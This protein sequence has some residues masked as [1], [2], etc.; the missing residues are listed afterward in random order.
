MQCAAGCSKIV[1]GKCGKCDNVFYCGSDC[2]ERAWNS[3][4]KF[5]CGAVISGKDELAD[6]VETDL[7][8]LLHGMKKPLTNDPLN[9]PPSPSTP[10]KWVHEVMAKRL[11]SRY[12]TA[13]RNKEMVDGFWVKTL[14]MR[15]VSDAVII[16][17]MQLFDKA[18][19]AFISAAPD[20]MGNMSPP[21]V[22][23]EAS[24]CVKTIEVLLRAAVDNTPPMDV[25]MEQQTKAHRGGG[26]AIGMK[27]MLMAT[28]Y[29]KEVFSEESQYVKD[30]AC[31]RSYGYEPDARWEGTNSEIMGKIKRGELPPMDDIN[32]VLRNANATGTFMPLSKN[33]SFIGTSHNGKGKEEEE[34]D[35]DT[36]ETLYV[37]PSEAMDYEYWKQEEEWNADWSL[38][39][40]E[41][42][43]V[44]PQ[45]RVKNWFGWDTPKPA[46]GVTGQIRGDY[47]GMDPGMESS[48]YRTRSQ[49]NLVELAQMEWEIMSDTSLGPPV[50]RRSCTSFIAR[51][52]SPTRF[53][54]L[55]GFT[56]GIGVAIGS[57]W[58]LYAFQLGFHKV[59]RKIMANVQAYLGYAHE[60]IVT[61]RDALEAVDATMMQMSA[62]LTA[63]REQF[64]MDEDEAKKI[65]TTSFIEM[66]TRSPSSLPSIRMFKVWINSAIEALGDVD[67]LN[68]DT[69]TGLFKQMT[70]AQNI[71]NDPLS[72][73]GDVSKA[74]EGVLLFFKTMGKQM[75][76]D[77]TPEKWAGVVGQMASVR[78]TTLN[79]ITSLDRHMGTVKNIILDL[80]DT[81][82]EIGRLLTLIEKNATGAR[83]RYGLE[84]LDPGTFGQEM[85]IGGIEHTL[86]ARMGYPLRVAIQ[87]ALSPI[88][89]V[90]SAI[91]DYIR[92]EAGKQIAKDIGSEVGAITLLSAPNLLVFTGV[93]VFFNHWKISIFMNVAKHIVNWSLPRW[94]QRAQEVQDLL[95]GATV[96]AHGTRYPYREWARRFGTGE[97]EV[98]DVDKYLDLM[99]QEAWLTLLTTASTS[100]VAPLVIMAEYGAISG[101]AQIAVGL[102]YEYAWIRSGI[103]T[104]TA[105]TYGGAVETAK[106]LYTFVPAPT[107][108]NSVGTLL[109]AISPPIAMITM[110]LYLYVRVNDNSAGP[111]KMRR[112]ISWLAR[113]G[114]QVA[115]NAPFAW[116]AYRST[117]F[118]WGTI[119]AAASAVGSAAYRYFIG[120]PLIMYRT[121]DQVDT[122]T[123]SEDK[124]QGRRVDK[125]FYALLKEK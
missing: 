83:V 102:T 8:T 86:N 113:A 61:Q 71:I 110:G 13:K 39:S 121:N 101:L 116:G 107:D 4:H 52:I 22:A 53:A 32:K 49:A 26:K 57:I 25:V 34:E 98:D 55:A 17:I 80:K 36:E 65:A 59:S 63:L 87:T 31:T 23:E 73:V 106:F 33:R 10:D 30:D 117:Y 7:H 68:N 28:R 72:S 21:G 97:I 118:Y 47:H 111:T 35:S 58:G 56:L 12:Y 44:R 27:I 75:Y 60:N 91:H 24:Q 119:T 76:G 48:D 67:P 3:I 100:L 69:F 62:D 29:S 51:Y 94:S 43:I 6:A 109:A 125:T 15:G 5:T 99:S 92:S 82:E 114:Y 95:T 81:N 103:M 96:G 20:L 85:L 120:T 41:P 37:P 54:K 84:S 19:R 78:N 18:E 88:T 45:S 79:L 104:G 16:E 40:E 105:A 11:E 77:L 74:T 90:T 122:Y 115:R 89:L 14:A 108:F 1:H 123:F 66:I 42:N 2:Q 38:V 112:K 93:F 70:E 46:T 124:K 64:P 50:F 9:A